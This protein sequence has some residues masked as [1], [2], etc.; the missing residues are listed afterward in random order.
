MPHRSPKPPYCRTI[1]VLRYWPRS[2]EADFTLQ[3]LH[4]VVRLIFAGADRHTQRLVVRDH[5]R[6]HVARIRRVAGHGLV[7]VRR[8]A[9][10]GYAPQIAE[11]A[12]LQNDIS[13]AVLAEIGRSG[14]HAPAT[15]RGSAFDLRRC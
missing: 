15:S 9:G 12:V 6:G 5:E 14:F 1:L 4:E 10:A 2:G 11:A 7:G 3:P 8:D 13:V